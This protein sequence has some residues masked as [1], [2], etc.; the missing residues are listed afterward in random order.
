VILSRRQPRHRA[1]ERQDGGI[2]RRTG[3]GGHG[4]SLASD[5]GAAKVAKIANGPP[6]AAVD[7]RCS[8]RIGPRNPDLSNGH[9]LAAVADMRREPWRA[10]CARSRLGGRANLAILAGRALPCPAER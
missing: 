7:S 9:R 5:T 1:G 4:A 8:F 2:G 3:I 10:L 6:L